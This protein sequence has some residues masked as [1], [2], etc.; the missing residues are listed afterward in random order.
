MPFDFIHRPPPKKETRRWFESPFWGPFLIALVGAFIAASAQITAIILPI[1]LGPTN[2][3]DFSIT[4]ESINDTITIYDDKNCN[5]EKNITIKDLYPTIKPYRHP[6][7]VK[8]VGI[9]PEGVNVLLKGKGGN[10][11]LN[12]QMT[13]EINSSEYKPG[14]HEILIQG[15]GE[16]GIIRNCTYYLALKKGYR[17]YTSKQQAYSFD[18][19]SNQP[20][21]ITLG[22]QNQPARNA[23]ENLDDGIIT[24]GNQD[25]PAGNVIGN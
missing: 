25:Q 23:I 22:N 3:C 14:D 19:S 4:I 11:P 5:I 10:L 6:V 7:Y 17:F 16:D 13:I 24:L 18:I 21:V 8:I 20:D 1:Y 12:I 15:I 2:L 9:L